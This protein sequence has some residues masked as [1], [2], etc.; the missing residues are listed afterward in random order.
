M[1]PFSLQRWVA[2]FLGTFILV[3]A[4]TGSVVVHDKFGGMDLIGVAITFGAIVMVLIFAFGDVSGAHFNPAVT[5][6]FTL[7]GYFPLRQV[8]PYV[9]SQCFGAIAASGALHLLFP[10]H[11][12]LGLTSFKVPISEAFIMEF[13]M[14]LFLMIVI[15]SVATGGEEKGQFAGFAVG[16]AVGVEALVGGPLTGASM[17]PARSLGPALVTGHTSQ[18]WLYILA[19]LLGMVVA[20]FWHIWIKKVTPSNPT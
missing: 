10:D 9:V 16:V 8:L 5:L 7:A 19:P 4:G 18:L 11:L 12:T 2:E 13:G 17:N 20:V 14:S 3:F 15:F 1:L 6:S